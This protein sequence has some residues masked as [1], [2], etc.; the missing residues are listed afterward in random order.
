MIIVIM[1][2][3]SSKNI[4]VNHKFVEKYLLECSIQ[5]ETFRKINVFQPFISLENFHRLQNQ[6]NF[7]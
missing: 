1:I 6:T 5:V 3:I 7:S 4:K 2:K